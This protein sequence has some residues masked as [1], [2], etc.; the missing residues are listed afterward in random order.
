MWLLL[1]EAEGG[2][3]HCGSALTLR[4]IIWQSMFLFLLEALDS[5][6]VKWPQNKMEEE[7]AAKRTPDS[8][9]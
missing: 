5:Q 7:E 3:N 4:L 9:E 6:A 1:H 8:E 2:Q